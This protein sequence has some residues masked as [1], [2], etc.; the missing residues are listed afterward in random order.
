MPEELYA[1]CFKVAEYDAQSLNEEDQAEQKWLF[2]KMMQSVKSYDEAFHRKAP[3]GEELYP[4]LLDHPSLKFLNQAYRSTKQE[5]IWNL[6]Y[7]PNPNLAPTSQ[8]MKRNVPKDKKAIL[9]EQKENIQNSSNFEV[10]TSQ[11]RKKTLDEKLNQSLDDLAEPDVH[12]TPAKPLQAITDAPSLVLTR[13]QAFEQTRQETPK[14]SPRSDRPDPTYAKSKQS[15]RGMSST[16][17]SY[18][19][20]EKRRRSEDDDK[21]VLT[22]R[23]IRKVAKISKETSPL[24]ATWIKPYRKIRV[25]SRRTMFRY[26]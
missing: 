2:K 13:A 11:Y 17:T 4:K 6:W 1:Q 18:E 15:A 3:M 8:R 12:L 23:S 9:D 21:A 7:K 16:A 20:G 25:F 14:F 5:G 22:P 26:V 10:D 19:T 24:F